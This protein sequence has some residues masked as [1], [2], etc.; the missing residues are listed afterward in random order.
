MTRVGHHPWDSA[1]PLQPGDPGRRGEAVMRGPCALGRGDTRSLELWRRET[2][3]EPQ[4]EPADS[5]ADA[6]DPSA[7]PS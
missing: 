3:G 6:P 4:A 1:T 5:W 7:I 2:Q